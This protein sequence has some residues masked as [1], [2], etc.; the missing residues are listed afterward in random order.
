MPRAPR[1]DVLG[2]PYHITCRGVK[3][4]P[5]FHTDEDRQQFLRF[6]SLTQ[7]ELPFDLHAYSLMTNHYHLLLQTVN[8]PLAK[9]MHHFQKSF[10]VWAN[11]TH[12]QSGHVFEARFHSIPVQTDAYFTTVARYIH[13]NAVRAGLVTRPEDYPWSDYPDLLA[14]KPHALV[15]PGFLLDYFGRDISLQREKYKRFVDEAIERPEPITMARLRRM[16]Y[17]GNPKVILRQINPVQIP[18]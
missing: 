5:L 2:L 17:W 12:Q 14:G 11:R 13:L 15:K 3:K 8:Y 16:R 4:L 7:K 9:I 6:L 10:A 18:Y 1:I